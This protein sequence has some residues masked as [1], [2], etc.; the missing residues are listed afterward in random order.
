[1]TSVIEE[2]VQCSSAEEFLQALSPIG[3]YFKNEETDFLWL[4]RGQGQDYPLIPSLFRVRANDIHT[5]ETAIKKLQMIT[6]QNIDDY[7]G[8]RYAERGIITSFF[9][10]ADKRGLIL[11]GDS[12]KLRS[13][14]EAWNSEE[15]H[16]LTTRWGENDELL[17]LIA[18]AQHYGIPTRF[19]DWTRKALIAAFFAA[20]DAL[21]NSMCKVSPVLVVWAFYFPVLGKHNPIDRQDDPIRI[22]TAPSATNPNLSAQRGVFTQLNFLYTK[23]AE[24]DY[25]PFDKFLENP[26]VNKNGL[27]STCKLRKFT[28]PVDQAN[29]LLRLLVKLDITPSAVYP[30]YQSIM[31]DLQMRNMLG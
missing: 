10:I 18:L 23:E 15:D 6:R 26:M 11:P 3:N 30:G 20:E 19:L 5:K 29:N 2:P 4:F 8:L 14:L 12:Q 21:R 17:S 1:M 28:L 9:D 16:W 22:V 27:I 31:F 7:L 13:S 24:G 25:P